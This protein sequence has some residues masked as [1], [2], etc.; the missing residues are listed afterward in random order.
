VGVTIAT[1][2]GPAYAEPVTKYPQAAGAALYVNKAFRNKPLTFL[3][4]VCMLSASFAASGAL[5]TGFA[6]YFKEVWALPPEL[7]L[8]IAFIIALSIINFIG[9]TPVVRPHLRCN[10]GH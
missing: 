3:I 8:T 6:S 9:I 7:L 2:T 4:T 10:R 5:A 1:I